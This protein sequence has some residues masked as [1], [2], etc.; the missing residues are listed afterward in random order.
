[1]AFARYAD[2]G[3]IESHGGIGRL[4]ELD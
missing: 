4:D 2:F 1:M 3:Q